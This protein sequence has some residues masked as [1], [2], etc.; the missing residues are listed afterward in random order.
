MRPCWVGES[1]GSEQ[2]SAACLLVLPGGKWARY[3]GGTPCRERQVW[4][5]SRLPMP[6]NSE[7]SV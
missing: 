1:L 2:H 5:G 4:S 6:P 3:E 7:R